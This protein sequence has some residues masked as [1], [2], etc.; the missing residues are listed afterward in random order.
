MVEIV[1]I[2]GIAAMNLEPLTCAQRIETVRAL[3]E[4][5]YTR[6]KDPSGSLLPGEYEVRDIGDERWLRL[7]PLLS[8]FLY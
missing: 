7:R 2:N 6:A 1:M 8:S 4:S 5:G 3:R